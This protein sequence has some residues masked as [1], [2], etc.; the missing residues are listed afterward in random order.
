MSNEE[1]ENGVPLIDNVMKGIVFRKYD[2]DPI[3]FLR[4]VLFTWP[5]LKG[6]VVIINGRASGMVDGTTC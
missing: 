4:F 5:I 2:Q 1:K 3:S 6:K